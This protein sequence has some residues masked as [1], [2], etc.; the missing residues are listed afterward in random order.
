[1]EDKITLIEVFH[2][3]EDRIFKELKIFLSEDPPH[4]F[5][6]T[7]FNFWNMA[8]AL[9]SFIRTNPEDYKRYKDSPVVYKIDKETNTL[10]IVIV[11]EE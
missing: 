1:M 5:S 9:G 2:K 7:S 11:E 8:D 6:A 10:S 3:F 4:G